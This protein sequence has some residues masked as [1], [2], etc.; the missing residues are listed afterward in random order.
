MKNMNCIECGKEI[1]EGKV[2]PE[3]MGVDEKRDLTDEEVFE[4]YAK[5]E[6]DEA[7]ENERPE[8]EYEKKIKQFENGSFVAPEK[9]KDK[10]NILHWRNPMLRE[11]FL[12]LALGAVF[13]L[14]DLLLFKAVGDG[15]SGAIYY[16]VCCAVI[17]IGLLAFSFV[18]RLP[19]ALKLDRMQRGKKLR[20][21]WTLNKDEIEE[22]AKKQ[23]NKNRFLYLLTAVASFALLI[24]SI[25]TYNGEMSFFFLLVTISSFVLGAI[26]TFLFFFMP[27]YNYERVIKNGR[28]V[29][30]GEDSVY[31]YGRYYYFG[32]INPAL[33]YAHINTKKHILTIDFAQEKKD[34][35]VNKKSVDVYVP[36]NA[37]KKALKLIDEYEES[38][39]KF[40]SAGIRTADEA[41]QK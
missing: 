28:D 32:G 16:A 4:K 27:K 18:F 1:T 25:A 29:L 33:T 39:K 37:E 2:C 19:R 35:G 14:I 15:T 40:R 6:T 22:A 23:K 24:Y 7:E 31:V 9:D 30:I 38:V 8:K 36:E 21:K 20:A 10:K 5:P 11:F 17:T 26:F 13:L 12:T 3:C 34:G 41:V